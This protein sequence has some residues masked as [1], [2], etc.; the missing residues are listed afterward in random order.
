[1]SIYTFEHLHGREWPLETARRLGTAGRLGT[2][3]AGGLQT[4]TAG[5]RP[6]GHRASE[7]AGRLQT[8][9]TGGLGSACKWDGR[10][11]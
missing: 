7:T 4:A 11:T 9:R 2:A 5:P 3:L 8:T 10:G 6:K 1:M